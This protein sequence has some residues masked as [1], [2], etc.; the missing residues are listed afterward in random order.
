MDGV[1][2]VSKDF[3][4]S[5]DLVAFLTQI[6]GFLLERSEMLWLR[7]ANSEKLDSCQRRMVGGVRVKCSGTVQTKTCGEVI[8]P[9]KRVI[10]TNKEEDRNGFWPFRILDTN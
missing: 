7:R 8:N 10:A 6:V 1:F 4:C 9:G 2:V 3:A 5:E